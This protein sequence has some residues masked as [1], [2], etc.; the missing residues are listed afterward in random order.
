[1]KK[2]NLKKGI[3]YTTIS[4]LWWGILGTIFFQYIS[5]AGTIEIVIHRTFWTCVILFLTTL[6]LN[7]IIILKKILFNRSNALILFF[8][9]ILIL[10]NWSTWIYA[11]STER[12][13][14][15]SYGYFIFP[16]INI[17]FGYIFFKEEINKK[18]F[19]SVIL[20]IISS[21]YLLFN[22]DSF[23]WV[24]VLVA[25]FWSLYNLLR[26]KI[27]VDTDIG[28]F[29][30]S[31]YLLPLAIIF[32]YFIYAKGFNDFSFQYPL[33]MILLFLAG[34]MT[35]IPLF[36]YIKGLEN[37]GMGASGMIFFITPTCQF[38][39][40]YF[41]Y[42]ETFSINKMISFIFIWFA[43]FIYITDLYEKN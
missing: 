39:L 28:L 8:T 14:D 42:N 24:G 35:V 29:I 22:F 10:A 3:T 41:Y 33:N 30:E 15:A 18:R 11:V 25:I 23:P 12:I 6:Y 20:V 19:L 1:M 2:N 7:K 9:S 40:G 4:S 26:K 32:F 34:P 38:L 43:V 16:I 37:A 5:Y 21:V 17:M 27:N 31:L 13:I 36:I